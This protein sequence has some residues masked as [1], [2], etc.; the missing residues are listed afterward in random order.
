[1]VFRALIAGIVAALFLSG[2]A[3]INA[4]AAPGKKEG[5]FP[6]LRRYKTVSEFPG[7]KLENPVSMFRDKASGEFYVVDRDLNEVLVLD[8][9]LTLVM[10]LGQTRGVDAPVA[11]VVRGNKIYVAMENMSEL[12]VF[13]YRGELIGKVDASGRGEFNPGPMDVGPDGFIYA[14]NKK[15]GSCYVIGLDD[16]V[17]RVIGR[18]KDG[19]GLS[20][21]T[22]VAADKGRV[23]LFTP[24]SG[25]WAIRVYGTDGS[26][27]FNFEGILGEGGTLRLPV[28]GRVDSLGRLWVVDAMVGLVVY[29]VVDD[30]IKNIGKLPPK[31]EVIDFPV[32]VDFDDQ[33]MVYILENGAKSITIYR[34]EGSDV[35]FR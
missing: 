23:F 20:G 5:G 6:E 27:L 19:S 35:D 25:Y 34:H 13:N 7:V 4:Q 24:F 26:F 33:G 8:A 18:E 15:D 9:S 12:L 17:T 2:G 21:L 32:S 11:A 16:R 3:V 29:E 1:M 31:G 10:R 30:K 28:S 14:V 22:G